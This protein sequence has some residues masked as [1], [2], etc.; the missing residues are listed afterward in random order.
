M[1]RG[2]EHHADAALVTVQALQSMVTVIHS[3]SPPW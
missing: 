1:A 2:I 3:D